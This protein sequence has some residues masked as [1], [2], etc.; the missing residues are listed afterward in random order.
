MGDPSSNLG[1]QILLILFLT[2]VN[3][4]LAGA[5]M[6]YVTVNQT[7]LQEM[8]D[9]G[10]K[11][12]ARVLH[13]LEDSDAFLSTIQVGITFAGFFSSASAANTF[14]SYLAPYLANVP[15]GETVATAIVT[16]ILS[17]F[18]LV[19]GE[20]YPKQLAMQIPEQYARMSSGVVS[21][22][23]TAFKPFVWLLTVSTNLIKK[24]TPIDFTSEQPNMT[25]DEMRGAFKAS[26][27]EGVIDMDEYRMMEGV[28]SLDD[29]LAREVM[30][31]RVDT[32]MLDIDDGNQANIDAILSS[33]FSRIPVFDTDKDDILG[34]VHSKDLLRMANKVGFD[35][36]DIKSVIKPV[37]FAPETIFID[38]LLLEFKRNHQHIAILKDEYGGV[39]GLVTMEDL[40]EEIVGEI[41]D[42]YDQISHLYK[43][44]NDDTYIINGIMALDKFN[45]IF[46]TALESDE[47]DTIAGYMIEQLGYFPA[48]Q[49][50]EV[51]QV[52]DWLLTTTAVENGRI[53]GMQVKKYQSKEDQIN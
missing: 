11:K 27:R 28:L 44:I 24:I 43:K 7:R 38:D 36:V 18:T 20:L 26:Q 42:E 16:L 6:A 15:A 30:V 8:A 35:N 22:L 19:L 40:L 3:A 50:E 49:A 32:F 9:N 53:R 39:V 17:Y 52:D 51:I 13:I 48:D 21:F 23:Q 14:V 5:E 2:F 45:E 4:F 41:E 34:I 10:D 25:R 31:P 37:Y 12:A 33:Q 47:S 1:G 46:D 29:K